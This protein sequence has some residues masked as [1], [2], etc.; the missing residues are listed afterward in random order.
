MLPELI[1]VV[2]ICLYVWLCYSTAKYHRKKH[3]FDLLIGTF[4]CVFLTPL[5]GGFILVTNPVED[6]YK[7]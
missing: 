2:I 4:I 5:I 7:A 3:K 1:N 6:K